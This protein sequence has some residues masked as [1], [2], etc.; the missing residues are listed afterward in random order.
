MKRVLTFLATASSIPLVLAGAADAQTLGGFP[1][2]EP[3]AGA[4]PSTG[5]PATPGNGVRNEVVVSQDAGSKVTTIA[6]AMK[7]VK[8]GGTI[9]VKGGVYN[10]NINVTKPVEIRGVPGDYGRNTVFRPASSAACV[11]ITPDT[12]LAAV[13]LSQL[14]FEF[15]ANA[16]SGPCVDI[17][18]GTVSVSDTYIIPTDANIP[19]RAAYGPMR[20]ELMDHL[21]RPPRDDA[22]G[23]DATS[24]LA[25]V[26]SRHA[27]P[28]G[29]D[30]REWS[31][32]SGGTSV[33]KFLHT[34]AARGV[35]LV[36]G[37][38][39][40]IRV[41]AGDVRLDGNVI[42]GTRTA[43][44]FASER[45][46]FIKGSMTNNVIIGNGVGIAAAGVGADLLVTRNTIR[47]N[48]GAG[49][50]A[51]VYDGVKIIANEILGNETGVFLSEKVRMATVNSNLVVQN[52]G[53]AMKVSSGFF[54]AVAGNTFAENGGCTMQ[55][56]SAEQKILN[57]A[58][59][60]VTAFEDFKPVVVYDQTNF[61]LGNDGDARHKKKKRRKN[62]DEPQGSTQLVACEAPL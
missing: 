31:Y 33:E 22:R 27:Q 19:L 4:K 15:D 8:P 18:G 9:L 34:R 24:Q 61:A 60:K 56:F 39:A 26:V 32:I 52:Y 45:N 21:A 10:E 41:A 53:D 3:G 62:K 51:D 40:G 23:Y 48:N 7:L 6:Q 36:T 35:G 5:G 11:S 50:R 43:V 12:P 46:A 1:I 20:P 37:P 29:A 49:V 38:S 13:S 59:I 57:N 30:H 16:V 54:G 28:V 44:N 25:E 55:F 47:Y 58:E 14:I 2:R 42:V 17:S